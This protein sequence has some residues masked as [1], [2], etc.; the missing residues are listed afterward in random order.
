[1]WPTGR[2]VTLTPPTV[3]NLEGP[4]GAGKTHFVK[5]MAL[6]LGIEQEVTSPTFTLL[7]S[8]GKSENRLHHFDFYRLKSEFEAIDLGLDDYFSEGISVVEWGNKFP[9]LLPPATLHIT[10]T[11]LGEY[12]REFSYYQHH[13][14]SAK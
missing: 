8:Y 3:I 4:L 5:G 12:E 10:I 1:M 9:Q 6:A 14:I 13:F 2:I 11:P 7:H